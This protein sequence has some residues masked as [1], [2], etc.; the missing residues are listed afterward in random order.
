M[1]PQLRPGGLLSAPTNS[2]SSSISNMHVWMHVAA[3]AAVAV[4]CMHLC[5]CRVW[6]GSSA[7]AARELG[8]LLPCLLCF[9]AGAAPRKPHGVSVHQRSAAAEAEYEALGSTW[10]AAAPAV[11]R[12]AATAE[13]A[14]AAEAAAR[15]ATKQKVVSMEA[16]VAYCCC[17]C[18]ICYFC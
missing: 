12:P 8:L 14:A 4:S 10:L 5:V 15:A 2:S 3:A 13:A 17:V 11:S 18:C 7:C 6:G 9:A 1:I 16:H